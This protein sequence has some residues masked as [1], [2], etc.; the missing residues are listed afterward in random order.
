MSTLTTHDI[1]ETPTPTCPH[2]GHQMSTDEMLY[3]KPT[4]DEDLFALA[5]NEERSA[6]ECPA[7]DQGYWVQ[8]GYRPHYTSAFAEDDL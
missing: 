4:C 8:G 2:C 6:I 3:G 5:P 7:C 1:F